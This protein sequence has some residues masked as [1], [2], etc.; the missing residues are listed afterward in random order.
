MKIMLII[1]Y[2]K[3]FLQV[4]IKLTYSFVA[5]QIRCFS[6]NAYLYFYISKHLTNIWEISYRGLSRKGQ[7]YI[8]IYIKNSQMFLVVKNQNTILL[9]TFSFW[10]QYWQTIIMGKGISRV[11]KHIQRN[12]THTYPNKTFVIPPWFMSS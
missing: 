4:F 3:S 7:I 10:P 5:I 9:L 12:C 8:L 2:S 1:L 6:K 11:Y